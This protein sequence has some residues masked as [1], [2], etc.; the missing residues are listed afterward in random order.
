ME[1]HTILP[2]V[3]WLPKATFRALMRRTGRSFFAEEANLNLMTGRELS[4]A[5]AGADRFEHDVSWVLLGGWP[6]N[7]LLNMRRA[8]IAAPR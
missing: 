8:D 5:A 4:R 1:F 6:S 7:L 3:H 2:V